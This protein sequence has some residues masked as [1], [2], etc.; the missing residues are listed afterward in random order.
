MNKVSLMSDKCYQNSKQNATNRIPRTIIINLFLMVILKQMPYHSIE[1]D[2]S[3][4]M[5]DANIRQVVTI[6]SNEGKGE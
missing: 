4:N 3:I 6:T 1:Y 2:L 5:G